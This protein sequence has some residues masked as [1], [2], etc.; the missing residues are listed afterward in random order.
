MKKQANRKAI[1]ISAALTMLLLTFVGGGVLMVSRIFAQPIDAQ[2]STPVVE[3]SSVSRDVAIAAPVNS[4]TTSTSAADAATI[5]ADDQIIAAY[6]A[7]L[8]QA[9]TDLND[10]YAQIQALQA[11]Q[12]QSPAPS[13]FGENEHERNE[14]FQRDGV[15]V[16]QPRGFGDD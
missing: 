3:P 16:L 15:I 13:F 12:S 5:A 8:E 10:A 11:T 14:Q 6:Q 1:V 4:A 9:Y 2:S 7:Q